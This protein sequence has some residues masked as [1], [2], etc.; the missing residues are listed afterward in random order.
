MSTQEPIFSIEQRLTAVEDAVIGLQA[1]DLARLTREQARPPHL[2]FPLRLYYLLE[3]FNAGLSYTTNDDGIHLSIGGNRILDDA[4]FLDRD[5]LRQLL[6]K[7]GVL[8][9]Q[10]ARRCGELVDQERADA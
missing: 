9:E 5:E 2:R 6:I 10:H 7:A 4:G 8:A 1:T 3:Q